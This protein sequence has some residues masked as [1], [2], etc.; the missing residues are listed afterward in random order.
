MIRLLTD[1]LDVVDRTNDPATLHASFI[2]S[3][4][5]LYR[6]LRGLKASHDAKKGTKKG[7]IGASSSGGGGVDSGSYHSSSSSGG[8]G[9]GTSTM[10]HGHVNNLGVQWI[11]TMYSKIHAILAKD[12]AG[13]E[14]KGGIEEILAIID[15]TDFRKLFPDSPLKDAEYQL[16]FVAD[17]SV[18][19]RGWEGWAAVLR[20]CLHNGTKCRPVLWSVCVGKYAVPVP[21]AQQAARGRKRSW[22][23]VDETLC[24]QRILHP[25]IS[26]FIS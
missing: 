9:T 21:A 12:S 11:A 22:E 19:C 26:T 8:D 4:K 1:T 13:G 3:L 16:R 17:S 14:W 23:G 6:A 7:T 5:E 24:R 18:T 2:H 25:G 10:N 15:T 20:S